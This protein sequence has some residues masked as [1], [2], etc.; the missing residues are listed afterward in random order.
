MK[1]ILLFD[2]NNK[3]C[4][5][6]IALVLTVFTISNS[7]AQNRQ[8]TGKVIATDDGTSLP[9]VSVQVK[10]TTVGTVTSV[11]GTYSVA[12]PANA[13]LVFSF[14][15]YTTQ[16]I[17]VGS[18][19]VINLKLAPSA[20]TLQQVNVVA[21][22]YGT[23]QRKDLT[24][25]V[26]SVGA[27]QIADVPV[28]TTDQALQGRAAG[29]QVTN[30]DGA[31]G[32]GVQ[33]QIRGLGTFGNSDPLYVVD[34]YPISGGLNQINPNDI[35]SIDILK[36]ASAT[37]IYG[38]RAAN[39]VVI[40][41]TKRGR[42][43]G[44][45]QI[46][47][48]AYTSIQSE[49]KMYK[50][51]N[52]QQFVTLAKERATADG[53][54]IE[55]EWSNP[56]AL[57][58]IDWQKELYQTGLRQSY[59]LSLRG[60]NE[61]VQ[62]AVS[63]NY[64]DQK[65]IVLLSGFKRYSTNVNVDYQAFK[66]LKAS[67]NIKYSR[68]DS[69]VRFGSGGQDAGFGIGSLTKLV[70]TMTGNPLTDL[71]K[72]ANGDYGYYTKSNQYL[73]SQ[74]NVLADVE[75][76][77]QK[78]LTNYLLTNESLE[79]TILPGLRIKTNFGINSS[80][81]SGYY[82]TPSNDRMNG[83][84]VLSYYSQSANN[85]FEYLWENTIAY[86]KT[87]GLHSIDFVGGISKQDNTYRYISG[88]GNGQV[89][90]VLR[91]LN[92][93]NNITSLTGSESSYALASQFAR[94]NYKF[95]DKYLVTGT[96]RRDGS[97]RFGA[98]N[99]FGIFPSGSVAWRAKN[100]SFLKDVS[101]INDLKFR[102]S[103]GEVGNQSSIGLFQYLSLYGTGGSATSSN[104][105]GYPIN[106]VYQEGL[107]LTT[108]PNPNLKWET[109][110]QTDF[111]LDAS[112]LGGNLTLTADYYIK[113]SKDFLL[114]IPV[115]AQ[116][117][118][119][120]LTENAGSIRNS[121]LELGLEYRESKAAFK[122]GVGLNFTTVKN[123]ILSLATGQDAIYNLTTLGFPNTGANSWVI[124]TESKV[125]GSI[126]S[127]YGYKTAGIFQ[128]QAEINAAN[129]AATAKNG[130]V[131]IPYQ[132]TVT[133]PGDRKFVDTNG[134]GKITSADKVELGSPLPKFYTGLN[135]DA[136]YKQF[137]FNA[138][139]FASV[140]NK[141]FNYQERTLESFGATNG[142]IGIENVSENYYLNRWTTT[143]PSNR[144]ARVVKD[145]PN[146]NTQPSDVYVEDGSFLK[147]R[148]VQIGYSLPTDLV[149][150]LTLSRIRIY[151]SAQNLFTITKYS[152][153]DPEIGQPNDP[154]TNTRNSTAS[155]ID[156]GTYPSSRYYTLGI[157]V[158]F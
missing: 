48:D 91:N 11:N 135:L 147:L 94:I 19:A 4:R 34:G 24:G 17:P 134:D 143:N 42:K 1:K 116:T 85:T 73:N 153:L 78:N 129:A 124:Y 97:S 69:Q 136:S 141:I 58:S 68:N 32:A 83:G 47:F 142:S 109:S 156:I 106:K 8:V 113:E 146:G 138:L 14:I 132:T 158:T 122:Y 87:F 63:F 27:K 120:S 80:D 12:A 148:S 62:T 115:P 117:G 31:P 111:G 110:K 101:A 100:E 75:T 45:V 150:K 35:A 15:G 61:K 65:G 149:K 151:L 10:G 9:G 107:V 16:E 33:V 23:T 92:S 56:A 119:T 50:V 46:N 88:Q 30:N 128:T 79:A 114:N 131:S 95:G 51:L 44:N 118:F 90:D 102:A 43:D 125:G 53:I 3:Y 145:D 57:H 93:V 39:G 77:D 76:Q 123:K 26:A 121:G 18:R 81:Y 37:A 70:P 20:T 154:G 98:N 38:T 71:P 105:F 139:L 155:G 40:I 25:S 28:T 99:R 144:Y 49:P 108:P 157:N 36:D 104:N 2:K 72:D 21:V 126:G 67:S 89:S 64:F 82:F 152:G 140:G 59:N 74:H 112:F 52:A 103:Y 22:G 127:F 133:Q 29:V 6:L 84:T 86:T 66:W 13:T 55:P 5:L 137:D 41:T 7:F 130:G 60:G 96:V 54:T